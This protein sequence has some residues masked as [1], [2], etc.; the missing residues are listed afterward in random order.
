MHGL[1]LH[2]GN[3]HHFT[4][5]QG[6]AD[7]AVARSGVPS[8]AVGPVLPDHPGTP[9]DRA[10]GRALLGVTAADTV[11]LV[12]AG[13]WG[14]GDVTGTARAIRDAGAGVPVVLCGRN[15]A[16]RAQLDDEPGVVAIG[17][18]DQVR[19]L[20]AAA[21]VR[22]AQRRRPVLPRGVRCRGAGRSATP[23]CRGTGTATRGPCSEAGV[24]ADAASEAE[25]IGAIRRLA[26]TPEGAAMAARAQALF[27]A[28]PTDRL[29]EL[30]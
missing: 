26:R 28:D 2:E 22:R 8:S 18:T 23:A 21:D 9:E 5:W 17:W 6:S 13:S 29:L 25:L 7:E 10:D 4:V 24:A 27:V 20:L 11:V 3:D 12:V 15:D 1:W 19:R 14:V 16:L 30:A